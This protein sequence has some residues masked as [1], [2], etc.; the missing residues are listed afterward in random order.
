MVSGR[1]RASGSGRDGE[2]SSEIGGGGR[3]QH[4]RGAVFRTGEGWWEMG[5]GSG[6]MWRG[7]DEG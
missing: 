4:G 5:G 2:K 1:G 6:S 7:V 3:G